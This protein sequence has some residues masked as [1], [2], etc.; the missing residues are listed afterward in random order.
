MGEND[1]ENQD[2]FSFTTGSPILSN[3][4]SQSFRIKF[5]KMEIDSPKVYF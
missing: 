4:V 5:S 3:K 2:F 1:P